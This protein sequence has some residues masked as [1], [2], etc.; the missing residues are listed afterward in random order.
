[1]RKCF[2]FII[3]LLSIASAHAQTI[4]NARF[5]VTISPTASLTVQ[6]SVQ[7]MIRV[8]DSLKP[9]DAGGFL[10]WNGAELPW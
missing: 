2:V 10:Q 6:E 7:G 5:S 3:L 1:M 4:E 9:Q 8:I